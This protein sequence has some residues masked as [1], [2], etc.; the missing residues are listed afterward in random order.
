MQN[1]NKTEADTLPLPVLDTKSIRLLVGPTDP[2]ATPG[3]IPA[4]G[5]KLANQEELVK[6]QTWIKLEEMLV[7]EAFGS[8][9]IVFKPAVTLFTAENLSNVALTAIINE[10][11]Q[12]SIKVNNPLHIV[13]NLKKI[14]LL[15]EFN[16]KD[17]NFSN[18]DGDTYVKTHF[19]K[20]AVLQAIS[21]QELILAVTPLTTGQLKLKGI[22]Y[23]LI[24]ST[25]QTDSMQVRGRQLFDLSALMS[26]ELTIKV[27]PPAPCLQVHFTEI[28][29]DVLSN[30]IQKVTVDLRNVSSIPLRNIFLATSVPHLI[31]ACEFEIERDFQYLQNE[32][33]GTREKLARKNHVIPLVLPEDQLESNKCFSFNLWLRAPDVK[34]PAVI[35]LLIYYENIDRTS[36]PRYRLVRHVWKMSVQ[37]SIGIEVIQQRSATSTKTG[38]LALSLKVTNLNKVFNTILTQISLLKVALLSS[39]WFLLNEILVPKKLTLNS[40]ETVYNVIKFK[41][42]I[43]KEALYSE[44]PL[45]VEYCLPEQ[46]GLAFLDFAERNNQFKINIFE[47]I[48]STVEQT[49]KKSEGIL[50]VQWQANVVDAGSKRVAIGQSQIA[51]EVFKDEIDEKSDYDSNFFCDDSNMIDSD[52]K[53]D[54]ELEKYQKQVTYNLLHPANICH[55]FQQKKMCIVPVKLMLHSVVEDSNLLIT[56]ITL[57]GLG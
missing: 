54:L 24:S 10:P 5:I 21:P 8:L 49:W 36:V 7:Q 47:E 22:C 6:E 48:D 3:K 27:L 16:T 4:S 12:V 28:Y 42:K 31:S 52:S 1:N 55:N 43:Q 29:S 26:S 11:I 30:E 33:G 18:K 39:Y 23:Y 53:E 38:K 50:I 51:M 37:E 32:T 34:G 46:A 20:A 9:P 44:L 41:R 45:Q 25:T 2:L 57:G 56:V 14:Y 15:W 17:G 35:D 40:Q 19:I 13:L